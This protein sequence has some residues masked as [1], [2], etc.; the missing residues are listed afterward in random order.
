MAVGIRGHVDCEGNGRST[1]PMLTRSRIR[2]PT[3]EQVST[4][5][6]ASHRRQTGSTRLT[7]NT[8]RRDVLPAFCNPTMVTSISVALLVWVSSSFRSTWMGCDPGKG[9]RSLERLDAVNSWT[10]QKVLSNQSYNIL[11]TPAMAAEFFGRRLQARRRMLGG[12]WSRR[13]LAWGK[14]RGL[15]PRSRTVGESEDGMAG[16]QVSLRGSLNM[17]RSDYMLAAAPK[18]RS[19]MSRMT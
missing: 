15:S 12:A 8:R 4:S 19:K 1:S 10:Y 13:E 3:D 9:P 14:S 16:D 2:R 6:C 17:L 18:D 11:K 5:R 7:D